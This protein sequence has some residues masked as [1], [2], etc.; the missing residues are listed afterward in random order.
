MSDQRRLRSNA[1]AITS[2][3]KKK[4]A[5]DAGITDGMDNNLA[6]EKMMKALDNKLKKDIDNNTLASKRMSK[7]YILDDHNRDLTEPKYLDVKKEYK[8]IGEKV[9]FK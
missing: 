1:T 8:S 5:I 4:L 2:E 3:Q 7:S 6:E 9:N